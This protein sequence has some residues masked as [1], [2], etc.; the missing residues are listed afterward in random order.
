MSN[1][2]TKYTNPAYQ[3]FSTLQAKVLDPIYTIKGWGSVGRYCLV[4][5]PV[6][7]TKKGSMA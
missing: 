4:Q 2:P 3:H 1:F 7:G 5:M 6:S